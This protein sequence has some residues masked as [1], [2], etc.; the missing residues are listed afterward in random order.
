MCA[1]VRSTQ[2]KKKRTEIFCF[3]CEKALKKIKNL[4]LLILIP[5]S[6]VSKFIIIHFS[7]KICH[8]LFTSTFLFFWRRVGSKAEGVNQNSHFYVLL[9]SFG[10]GG[11]GG[12]NFVF[13]FFF[14]PSHTD[15][16]VPQCSS[17]TILTKK[18]SRTK[19]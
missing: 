19:N 16:R 14:L 2:K 17:R 1:C 4:S 15:S 11:G 7:V 6:E 5:P 13:F 8:P 10:G 9:L 12:R 3:Q 18:N